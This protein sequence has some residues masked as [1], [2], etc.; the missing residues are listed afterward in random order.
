MPQLSLIKQIYNEYDLK[1]YTYQKSIKN[2]KKFMEEHYGYFATTNISKMQDM[3]GLLSFDGTFYCLSEACE[4]NRYYHY[5]VA[6]YIISE[7]LHKYSNI[8][9]SASVNIC[10]DY[11]FMLIRIDNI[12]DVIASHAGNYSLKQLN[13]LDQLYDRYTLENGVTGQ[14]EL[15]SKGLILKRW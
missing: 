11:N 1:F 4:A 12:D 5:D 7:I 10:T 6:F 14:L 2:L 3:Q 13:I 15:R 9:A 8:G